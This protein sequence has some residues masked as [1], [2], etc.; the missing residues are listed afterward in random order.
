MSDQGLLPKGAMVEVSRVEGDDAGVWATVASV[1]AGGVVLA[2]RNGSGPMRLSAGERVRVVA[3]VDGK[4]TEVP[5][6]VAGSSEAGVAVQLDGSPRPVERRAFPRI[7]ACIPMRYRALTEAEAGKVRKAIRSRIPAGRSGARPSEI[8]GDRSD[9]AA[10][11]QR[12]QRIETALELLRDLVLATGTGAPP[13]VERDV[14]LSAGG[15]TFVPDDGSRPDVGEHV[16]VEMLLPLAEPLRVRVAGKVVRVEG[17]R[18]AVAL[19]F[20]AIDEGDRDEISRYVFQIQRRRL[21][22]R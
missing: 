4:A 20:D 11:L 8:P 19:C 14:G 16:E 6:V 9:M 22:K 21:A 17:D 18:G 10:V 2:A 1:A 15:M 5:G 3:V 13:M 7:A 12:L